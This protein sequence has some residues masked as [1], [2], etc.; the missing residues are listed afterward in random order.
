MA[1]PINTILL[2]LMLGGVVALQIFLSRRENR[3]L[4]LVF[5][6]ISLL[7]SLIYVFSIAEFTRLTTTQS[8]EINE[9]SSIVTEYIQSQ[10]TEQVQKQDSIQL[11]FTAGSVFV[12]GNIPTVILLA[13]YFGCRGERRKRKALEHMQVQDLE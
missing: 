7:I 8:I 5:P 11:W 2:L 12:M 1:F 4:G 9:S 3:F 10:Q 6:I 13:I